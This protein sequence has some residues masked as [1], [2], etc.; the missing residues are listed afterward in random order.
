MLRDLV[1]SPKSSDI[2]KNTV[3]SI[4]T[5]GTTDVIPTE[6]EWYKAAYHK[7]D[8]VTGNLVISNSV[9]Q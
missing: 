2:H 5:Y 4:S 3:S 1:F 9:E 6:D 8:G 7:N